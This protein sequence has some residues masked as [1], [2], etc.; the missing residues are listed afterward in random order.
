MT[1]RG[2]CQSVGVSS[3]K[4]EHFPFSNKNGA[5]KN[6]ACTTTTFS[7]IV[8]LR[9]SVEIE[10]SDLSEQPELLVSPGGVLLALDLGRG[11]VQ[12]HG[13]PEVRFEGLD[14]LNVC[15]ALGSQ[16]LRLEGTATSTNLLD[17]SGDGILPPRLGIA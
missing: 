11:Q 5:H 4:G 17:V 9:F 12:S 1:S 16:R 8:H 2:I 3:R 6:K 15:P 7:S 10:D 14:V 13:A